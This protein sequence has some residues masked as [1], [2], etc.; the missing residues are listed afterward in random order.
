MT[1]HI[2]RPW[3]QLTNPTSSLTEHACSAA[4]HSP[5]ALQLLAKN[6]EAAKLAVSF[7]PPAPAAMPAVGG[8]A[9]VTTGIP[10]QGI[11]RSKAA[12]PARPDSAG[13]TPMSTA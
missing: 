10:G 8:G 4:A 13:E 7:L 9:T 11:G 5:E 12:A 1:R 6:F 2:Q 3:Q